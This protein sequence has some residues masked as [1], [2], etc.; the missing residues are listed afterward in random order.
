[1]GAVF[2]KTAKGQAELNARTGVLTP[3]ARRV[4]ILVDG[5]RTV[6]D[7]DD[8]VQSETL[9][10]TLG[11]LE[12]DGF[13]EYIQDGGSAPAKPR[14]ALAPSPSARMGAPTAGAAMPPSAGAP[15]R[16][17]EA[18][19]L[20]SE[21]IHRCDSD[22]RTPGILQQIASAQ[23]PADLRALHDDWLDVITASGDSPWE[24]NSLRNRLARVL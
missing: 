11:Q 13:I 4:L 7:L 16:L 5:K 14:P 22:H 20:M 9:R 8:L 1:M 23:S 10:N 15:K 24:V 3:R 21:A 2:V 18:R 12:E 17:D 19:L 6:D